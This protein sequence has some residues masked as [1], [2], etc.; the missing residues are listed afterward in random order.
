MDN[1]DKFDPNICKDAFKKFHDVSEPFAGKTG[2]KCWEVVHCPQEVMRT[3]PAVLQNSERKC[4]LVA[5]SLSGRKDL[6][7]HCTRLGSC[8]QCDFYK[9]AKHATDDE[10]AGKV[11]ILIVEDEAIVSMEIQERVKRLGY[12][13]CDAVST[14]EMA[15]EKAGEKHPDLVL[16][17]VRLAGQMDGVEAA[18]AIQ[19]QFRIPV[20][21]LTANSDE[22]TVLR[23]KLTEP[24][25]FILKPFHERDL[26][27]NIEMAMYK[28]KMAE[29]SSLQRKI[30]DRLMNRT[31]E[32]AN[33][34]NMKLADE[35]IRN[36]KLALTETSPEAQKEY[37]LKLAKYAESL[38]SRL[39]KKPDS[40]S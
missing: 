27:T 12:R 30:T 8:K 6:S 34:E 23:A 19:R 4:W 33:Q 32:E 14:G 5:G 39:Q 37:L 18:E 2:A 35:I 21:Y 36:T 25:G 22:K 31:I 40:G 28:H 1:K 24:F 17:D 29:A 16:M 20:I 3:C 13:V 15:I 7:P 38:N 10:E 9:A 11:A 26:R